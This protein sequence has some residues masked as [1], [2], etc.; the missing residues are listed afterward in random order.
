MAGGGASDENA[1]YDLSADTILVAGSAQAVAAIQEEG[2]LTIAAIDLATVRDGDQLHVSIPLTDELTNIS[3]FTEVTVTI[4]I[5]DGLETRVIEVD[6]ID[7]INC[8]EGWTARILTQ[9]PG[10]R[11]YRGDW[12]QGGLFSFTVDGMDCEAIGEALGRRG[13]AVR[14]GLHCAPL[15]HRTAGTLETGTV[16]VSFSA[17]SQPRQVQCA[18]AAIRAAVREGAR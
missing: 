6:N 16:R 15:A 12:C 5:D 1:S 8:P 11:I 10:I 9:V 2:A 4:H 3:G 7:Y 14:A 18:A 13:I 17:F